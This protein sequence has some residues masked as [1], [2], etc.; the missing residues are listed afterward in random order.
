VVPGRAFDVGPAGVTLSPTDPARVQIGVPDELIEVGDALTLSV[1]VERP[2]GLIVTSATSYDASNGILTA[3]VYELGPIAAVI[4]TD[5]I[6]L[7]DI[8][9]LP[10][11]NGGAIVPVSPPPAGSGPARPGPR[12]PRSDGRRWPR[13][14]AVPLDHHRE[15]HPARGAHGDEPELHVSPGH[16]VQNG[17]R[18]ATARGAEGVTD[19]E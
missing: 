1:A 18:E 10:P 12:L 14:S 7:G 4:A 9:D 2:D 6:T 13:R 17:D 19:R 5:A 16:L 3:K 15:A 8:A 11:L